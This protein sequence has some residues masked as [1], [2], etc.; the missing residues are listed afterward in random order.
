MNGNGGNYMGVR[1]AI[2]YGY[3]FMD[4]FTTDEIANFIKNHKETFCKSAKEFELYDKVLKY[5][6]AE[7]LEDDFYM[8]GYECDNSSAT[9]IRAA[10]SNIMSRETGINF[11]YEEGGDGYSSPMIMLAECM[12][13][14]YNDI[15]KKL[16]EKSLRD[17]CIKYAKE[18]GADKSSVDYQEVEYYY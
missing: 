11:Q 18:L 14:Y 4:I 3:G 1:N 10:I 15:E 5:T 6:N 16:T 2:I 12:P 9:G 17:I 13:W 7:E 8:S